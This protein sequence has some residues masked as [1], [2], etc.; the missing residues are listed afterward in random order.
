MWELYFGPLARVVGI[1]IDERCKL[2]ETSGAAVRIGSQAD[3]TFLQ[4]VIDEFGPPDVVLDDGSHQMDDISRTFK[5]LYPRMPKNSI[6]M[7]EDLHTAY[8]EEYG[9]GLQAPG[10]FI[11]LA[12]G[13]VDD[14]YAQH[15]RGLVQSTL[16]TEQTLSISFYDS[17]VVFEKG[18][19]WRKAPCISGRI[20]EHGP[21]L[22]LSSQLAGHPPPNVLP[23]DPIAAP[24]TPLATSQM[25]FP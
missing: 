7:I 1:D 11:N 9:G 15:T 18:N 25:A 19:V 12:K 23:P 24:P 21:Q 3:E 10:S 2:H 4:Q 8:W 22:N 5:F 16:I 17:I 20:S 13:F 14:L 6:Y